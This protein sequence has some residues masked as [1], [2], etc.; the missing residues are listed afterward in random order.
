MRFTPFQTIE[1]FQRT[2]ARLCFDCYGQLCTIH[3]SPNLA[4]LLKAASKNVRRIITRSHSRC[5]STSRVRSVLADVKKPICRTSV[6]STNFPLTFINTLRS[7]VLI[8]F[9]V[10]L[11]ANMPCTFSIPGMY[12]SGTFVEPPGRKQGTVRFDIPSM[13]TT[14]CSGLPQ[15][16]PIGRPSH[17][18][19]INVSHRLKAQKKRYR[20]T[21]CF[22]YPQP[23]RPR[24]RALTRDIQRHHVRNSRQGCCAAY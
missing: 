5:P 12:T 21:G 17:G 15:E 24:R 19:R 23:Q 14:G 16:Y 9:F 7:Y 1:C 20:R 10:S 2:I 3:P 4:P 22:E 13:T 18:R 6:T 8:F 11:E